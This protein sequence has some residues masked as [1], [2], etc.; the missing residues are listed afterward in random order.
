[1]AAVATAKQFLQALWGE[2]AGVAELTTIT[3]KPAAAPIVKPYPWNYPD[4]LDSLLD[5]AKR[6]NKHTNVYMGVCL[7]KERWKEGSR[8]TKALALSSTVIWLD[9]DFKGQITREEAHRRINAFKLKPSIIVHTGGGVHVYWMLKELAVGGELGIVEK[10]NK[11]VAKNL[12]GD[13]TGDAARILRIPDHLNFKYDPPRPVEIIYWNPKKT[14]ILSDFSFLS[15]ETGFTLVPETINSNDLP[16]TEQ[17][18]EARPTP[19]FILDDDTCRQ[20]GKLFSHIWFEGTR[21]NMSLCVAG[22]LAFS[23]IKLEHAK[24]IVTI[25]SNAVKGDTESKLKNVED[26]YR[27]FVSGGEVKGRPSLETMVDELPAGPLKDQARKTLEQIQKL[28]PKQKGAPRG[29]A[30]PDFKILWL[31]KYTSEPAVW[32]ATLEKDGRK[33]VTKTEHTRFMKYEVFVED[34]FDQNELGPSAGLKNPQWR[35]MINEARRNGLYKETIAPPESKPAGAIE[36]GLEEF[37][38]ESHLNPDIGILKKFAG[39]DDD[40]SFYRLETFRGFLEDQGRK[41]SQNQ[42]T[43]KLKAMGWESKVRRFGKK[44]VHV[45]V[46]TL[47]KGGGSNGNGHSG[48]NGDGPAKI[49]SAPTN[50]TP[51]L[52]PDLFKPE[53]ET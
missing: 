8:G 50:T 11:A 44:T 35:H 48:G 9:L 4:S 27:K 13:P 6:H 3:Y 32:T 51:T 53:E 47:L 30:E 41:F 14:Y 15:T 43:E 24:T 21:H 28:M 16:E 19:T 45:W 36:K 26:T 23:G 49:P 37:L 22:W 40:D 2:Q 39:H 18:H 52:P 46:K 17:G 7:R 1:M 12:G 10:V 5:A 29:Q 34:V 33:L 25:A 38:A 20:L 42:L 31:E